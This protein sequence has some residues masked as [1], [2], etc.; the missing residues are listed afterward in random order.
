MTVTKMDHA[1][2]SFAFLGNLSAPAKRNYGRPPPEP[3]S[4][5]AKSKS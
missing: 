3:K 4:R 2:L 1:L 5:D